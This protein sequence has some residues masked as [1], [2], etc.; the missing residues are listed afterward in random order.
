MACLIGIQ[1]LRLASSTLLVTLRHTVSRRRCI[2][3]LLL[4]VL[5]LQVLFS[6][7]IGEVRQA[8]WSDP[9]EFDWPKQHAEIKSLLQ[10]I[11]Y[12]EAKL[13]E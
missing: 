1:V 2:V 7:Q 8:K 3:R 6:R 9:T 12:F 4:K 5:A 11:W 13:D 10:C